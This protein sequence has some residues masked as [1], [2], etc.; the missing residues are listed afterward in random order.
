MR[1]KHFFVF[2]FSLENYI[3]KFDRKHTNFVVRKT[4]R[5]VEELGVDNIMSLIKME[6]DITIF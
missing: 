4:H 3:E 1:T 5:E 6:Q 2:F